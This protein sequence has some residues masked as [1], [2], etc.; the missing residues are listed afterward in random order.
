MT[1]N[2]THVLAR[3]ADGSSLLHDTKN[4]IT[5]SQS[6]ASE[7]E[8]VEGQQ[9]AL[10]KPN[11]SPQRVATGRYIA[12]YHVAAITDSD[13]ERVELGPNGRQYI[14]DEGD[15]EA[16]LRDQ[17]PDNTLTLPEARRRNEFTE[18]LHIDDYTSDILVMA[19]HGG[20]IEA[21]TTESADWFH[22]KCKEYGIPTD[23]Y[24]ARG[25]GKENFGRWHVGSSSMHLRSFPKLREVAAR[26]YDLAV[27]FHLHDVPNN[28]ES[29]KV[30]VGG[31][32]GSDLRNRVAGRLDDA[33]PSKYDYITDLSQHSMMGASHEN[34]VNWMTRD[35]A[36]GLQIE[37][38]PRISQIH[39]KTVGR[40]VALAVLAYLGGESP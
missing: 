14:S 40:E 18:T 11:A 38:T 19:Y 39:R 31:R 37:V 25:Y 35:G 26:H 17:V 28:D 29:P 10:A 33:L 13:D 32:A 22:K 1:H 23:V 2:T 15:F 12:A 21:N 5:I 20:D 27:S 24:T 6:I 34:I 9:V 7:L 16:E 8:I 30:L 4:S 36:S 3:D